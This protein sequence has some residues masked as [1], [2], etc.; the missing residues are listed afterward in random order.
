MELKILNLPTKE[1]YKDLFQPGMTKVGEALSTVLDSANLILLPLKLINQRSKLYFD[2][3]IKR[4]SEK[5]ENPNL[6]LTQVQPYVGLPILEKLTYLEQNELSESFL[7]LLAKA[8]FEETSN[9]VHP[10]FITILNNLSADEAK[11]LFHY[12]LKDRIPLIELY[13][14]RYKEEIKKP[15]EEAKTRDNIK[16]LIDYSFQDR[17]EVFI[18][19]AKNLTGIENEVDL[20]FPKNIDLYIDNLYHNGLIEFERNLINKNDLD[21]YEELITKDYKKIHEK[22]ENQLDEIRNEKNN[23]DLVLEIEIRKQ[24]IKFTNLGKSFIKACIVE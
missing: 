2:V 1:I 20:I 6:T 4:Y 14:R 19:Y 8:S 3:N 11:I 9:L 13:I 7:N 10:A 16:R 18:E 17:E 23:E 24:S 15:D 22:L 12:Y 5:L 21:K